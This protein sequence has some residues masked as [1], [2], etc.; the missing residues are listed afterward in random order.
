MPNPCDQLEE[1]GTATSTV[2][3]T[4]LTS[5][6]LGVAAATSLL[7]SGVNDTA[8]NTANA[9]TTLV[10][11]IENDCAATGDGLSTLVT[12]LT[13]NDLH[14]SAGAAASNVFGVYDVLAVNSGNATS[15]VVSGGT[16]LAT[17]AGD[18]S[19]VAT[20][21]AVRSAPLLTTTGSAVSIL[22][23]NPENDPVAGG[24]AV[25]ALF[26]STVRAALA[27]SAGDASSSVM[28]APD[29][30]TWAI[31]AGQAGSVLI[32]Q[33]YANELVVD[34]ASGASALAVPPSDRAWVIN[35]E[36]FASWRYEDYPL[37]WATMIAGRP[38]GL[39]DLGLHYM[40]PTNNVN[41]SMDTGWKDFDQQQLKRIA[42]VYV[43]GVIPGSAA[44][45]VSAGIGTAEYRY[46][47]ITNRF[48]PGKG[49]HARYWKFKLTGIGTAEL[50]DMRADLAVSKR[51]V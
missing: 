32:S 12:R 25:S 21:S 44:V 20:A 51:R 29:T 33:L 36:S 11:P 16:S 27:V 4:G 49:L 45:R 6:L 26:D 34:T 41:W 30:A 38:V 15:A 35:T 7:F 47:V 2:F 1:L 43:G 10:A 22:L 48:I 8:I 19:S 42:Y 9:T 5:L 24:N 28:G 46:P 31:S 40:Q 50:L 37:R 13:A 14:T 18:A 39:S 23:A 17:S 3:G